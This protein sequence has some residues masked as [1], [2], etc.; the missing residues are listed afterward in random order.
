MAIYNPMTGNLMAEVADGVQGFASLTDVSVT[1]AGAVLN[2][3]ASR[4]NHALVVSGS[5]TA[6]VVLEGSLDGG[7]FYPLGT[8]DPPV[9][10]GTHP[11]SGP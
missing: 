8:A 2:G 3:G 6:T 7:N 4:S 5:G 10:R 11:P 9:S 1:G